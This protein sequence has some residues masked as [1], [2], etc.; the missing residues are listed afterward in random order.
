VRERLKNNGGSYLSSHDPREVLG[1]ATATE[2]NELEIH[3]PAPSK[4]VE[5]LTHLAPNRYIHIVE[6]KGVV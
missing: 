5:K 4:Q 3:W 2:I 6:G 1:I